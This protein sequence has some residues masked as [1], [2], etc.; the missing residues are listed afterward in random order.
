MGER[1]SERIA[2]DFECGAVRLERGIGGTGGG[3]M[4][5]EFHRERLRRK[6]ADSPVL[7]MRFSAMPIMAS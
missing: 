1:A 5:D 2:G 4:A 3:E 7:S 6:I